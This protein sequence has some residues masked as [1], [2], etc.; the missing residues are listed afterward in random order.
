VSGLQAEHGARGLAVVAVNVDRPGAVPDSLIASLHDGVTVV[1]DPDRTIGR[2]YRLRG[3]PTT[4]LFDRQGKLRA[5]HDGF[6][7]E[8]LAAWEQAVEALLAEGAPEPA[9]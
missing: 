4:L 1:L 2:P 7:P 8:R 6:D 5:R 9:E 3:L